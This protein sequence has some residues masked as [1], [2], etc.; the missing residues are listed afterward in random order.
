[1]FLKQNIAKIV[2]PSL[3]QKSGDHMENQG[4]I[5]PSNVEDIIFNVKF[6]L[7]GSLQHFFN[8]RSDH[9]KSSHLSCIVFTGR[10][11]R[12]GGCH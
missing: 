3:D 6:P 11:L 4:L 12:T 5:G 10:G 8:G 2:E 9:N 7:E 1:M